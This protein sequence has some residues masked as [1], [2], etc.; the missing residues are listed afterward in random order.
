MKTKHIENRLIELVSEIENGGAYGTES[1]DK[2]IS[3]KDKLGRMINK[4]NHLSIMEI[5]NFKLEEFIQKV[6]DIKN[7]EP[8]EDFQPSSAI[9]RREQVFQ[10]RHVADGI[11]GLNR[12]NEVVKFNRY[13][14]KDLAEQLIESLEYFYN[15]T[16]HLSVSSPI[17]F[18]CSP[19]SGGY[20][21]SSGSEPFFELLKN[22][23]IKINSRKIIN[24][25][26][27]IFLN[28]AKSRILQK[29]IPNSIYVSQGLK[30]YNS[31]LITN[32]YHMV[33]VFPEYSMHKNKNHNVFNKIVNENLC[34]EVFGHAMNFSESLKLN[35][36]KKSSQKYIS[37]NS[38]IRE[39]Y[40]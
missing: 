17:F 7:L 9:K 33:Q 16:D 5:A 12:I 31:S 37:V 4:D 2:Y 24:F 27:D 8:P 21:E 39:L 18:Q 26:D 32:L 1:Y 11:V 30:E 15:K 23:T 34:E 25:C 20:Y 40:G 36:E 3:S 38:E 22:V 29:T 28:V 14:G 10:T 6:D 35:F 19:L 13:I